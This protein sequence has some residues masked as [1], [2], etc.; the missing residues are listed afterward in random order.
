MS[1]KVLVLGLLLSV[2]LSA[3]AWCAVVPAPEVPSPEA[4]L[5]SLAA[6]KPLPA[7]AGGGSFCEIGCN[8]PLDCVN[9]GWRT[10]CT[11]DGTAPWCW[12]YPEATNCDGDCGCM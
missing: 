11:P 3:S 4:F 1:K 12:G 5:R 8:R 7:G 10:I 9:Q 2:G 6:P